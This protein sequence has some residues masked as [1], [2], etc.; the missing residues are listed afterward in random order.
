MTLE[1]PSAIAVL[2]DSDPEMVIDSLAWTLR[3]LDSIV[4]SISIDN[5]EA[6]P[7]W[8]LTQKPNGMT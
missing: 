7:S 3:D 6:S 2:R 1:L 4:E 8:V 5:V